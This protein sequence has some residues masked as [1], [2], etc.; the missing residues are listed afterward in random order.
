MEL[1]YSKAALTQHLETPLPVYI[2]FG[3]DDHSK[4][5][6]IEILTTKL[7]DPDF[8]DFD[9]EV[10]D[11]DNTSVEDILSS[12]GMVPFN[13]KRRLI[14]IRSAQVFK[15]RERSSDIERLVDGIS[16]LSG[17]VTLVFRVA[18][19][20]EG[21]RAKTA[22]GVK[23]DNAVKA[24][25][26]IVHCKQLTEGELIA[27]INA[28]IKV[29]GKSISPDAASKLIQAAQGHRI[30]LRNELE[31]AICYAGDAKNI[32]LEMVETVATFDPEDVMFKLVDSIA[33]RKTD[34]ALKLFHEILR[35]ENKPQAVAGKLLALLSRQYRMLLQAY[36]LAQIKIDSNSI[37]SLPEEISAQLPG[38]G[39]ILTLMWKARD[40]FGAVKNMNR[41]LL[42]RSFDLILEC[43]MANKGG[44]EGSEDVVTNLQLLILKLCSLK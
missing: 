4:D 16:K 33:Q 38:E 10:M 5:E 1:V 2:L 7:I 24:K 8:A 25:G 13:S 28:E 31:K 6:A 44:Q 30:A 26:A 43:D 14:I 35:R 40:L 29:E 19:E 37:R 39:S 42:L 9:F 21:S 23:F 34:E 27:W 3:E 18:A 17:V 12:S 22:I 11:A 20:E 15:K 36:E 41:K 32:T